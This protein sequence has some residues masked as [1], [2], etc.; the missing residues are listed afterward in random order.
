MRS[1]ILL[2]LALGLAACGAG[3]TTLPYS[4][5]PGRISNP[6]ETIA[7]LILANTVDGCVSQP[8][9]DETLLVVKFVC[10]GNGRGVGNS[11]ARLDQI[12]GIAVQQSGEWYRV[13]VHHKNGAADFT[14]SSK[15]LDDTQHLADAFAA[16]KK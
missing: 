2:C 3:I 13:L 4:P 11:V 15:S 14:W 5:Q 7:K 8:T 6:R 12:D 1:T 10:T 16:I 9:I